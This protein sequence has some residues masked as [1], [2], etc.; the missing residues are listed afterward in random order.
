MTS[1]QKNLAQVDQSNLTQEKSELTSVSKEQF[2]QQVKENVQIIGIALIIA[3]LIR[4]FIAEPRYI[5]SDSMFPT[6]KVGDRL[7]IEKV[8]HWFNPPHQ[9][10]IIVF[11][12]PVEL[13]GHGKGEAFIK[14][15]IGE[16][17]RTVAVHNGIV[18]VDNVPLEE[19]YI[20]Q[21]PFYE[22]PTIKVPEDK[23]FVMGDNR[24]NSNDS[25]VWGFLPEKNIIGRAM[26]RFWP[27]Q[28]I[29]GI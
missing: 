3:L 26:F 7:V 27:L 12:P 8:S 28:R 29:G 20:A 6:L 22:L 9:G 5:P 4:V 18:Y 21:P 1:E 24:N 11:T 19:N 16:P 10:D 13:Q 25:H 15:V 23:L 2:W 14:R 17:G